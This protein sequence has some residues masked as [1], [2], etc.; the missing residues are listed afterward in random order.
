M[1][2]FLLGART[3]RRQPLPALL[4]VLLLALGIATVVVVLLFQRALEDR[5]GRDACG[6]DLVVGAKGSGLQLVL[7]A[8]FSRRRADRQRPSP[9]AA[10]HRPP[11]DGGDAIWWSRQ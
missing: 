9:G 5:L 10:R 1:N 6:I 4:T 8:V 3:V 11:S 2:A 7:S